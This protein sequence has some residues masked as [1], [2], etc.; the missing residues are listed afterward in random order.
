M[1]PKDRTVR[2][3]RLG[4]RATPARQDPKVRQENREYKAGQVRLGQL[5]QLD[6]RD[7][8][9]SR[10]LKVN[11]ERKD[12]PDHKDHKGHKDHRA[13]KDPLVPQ[14]RLDSKAILASRDPLDRTGPLALTATTA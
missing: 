5:A 4:R 12:P 1:A 7:R 8:K 9:V 13:H 2:K 11:K 6:L 10:A 3:V 14:V